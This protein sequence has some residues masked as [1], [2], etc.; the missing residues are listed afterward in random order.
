MA[1]GSN[2]LKATIRQLDN[3]DVRL[4]RRAVRKLFELD[5]PTAIDA[6]IPLLKDPDEWFRGKALMAIQRWAS[7]KD[8]PLTEKLSKSQKPEERILAC[9]IAPR[10]G[11]SSE[12]ILREMLTD[13][14]NLVKQNAW[15]N[16]LNIN[17]D[18]IE[19]A[20]DND[21]VGIRVLAIER[22][23]L[24]EEI[25]NDIIKKILYDDS[26][27]I[28][29]KAINL[30]RSR[31]GIYSSGEFDEIIIKI[32]ENDSDIQI[33]ALIMLI[34]SGKENELF[35][36]K[37]PIWLGNEDPGMIKL[38]VESMENKDW[39]EIEWLINKI[40]NSSNDKL[41]SR[42]LRRK[43][44]IEADKYRKEIL[45]D[46]TRDVVIR[47]RIIEDLFGKKQ[48]EEITEIIFKLEKNEN[49]S[50]SETAKM[51]RKSIS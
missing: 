7:M 30:L 12:T 28:R 21:D 5:D 50:I 47:S 40:M 15:K 18:F 25:N 9:R 32:V 3:K 39:E 4:R 6:F 23:Q 24:M 42:V 29:K 20:L 46:E 26:V 14:N 37:I 34:E 1:S 22:I 27:R 31:P 44:T 45:L 33:D 8:L 38:I 19:E 51:Y 43:R 41:I 49:E 11:K 16:I 13:E 36:Q 2:V 35:S 10:I 48:D 17:E